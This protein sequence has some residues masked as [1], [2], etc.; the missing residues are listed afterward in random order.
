MSAGVLAT[1]AAGC[2]LA[3]PL[4][5][6]DVPTAAAYKEIAPWTLAQPADRLPR[7]AWWTLY[8]DAQLDDLQKQL[9]ASNPDLAAALASY[10]QARAFSDEAGSGLFPTLTGN[11]GIERNRQSNDA[12]LRG[13][14]VG[15]APTFYD[16]NTVGVAASYELDLWGQVRNEVASGNA[17]AAASAADLESVRLSLLAQLADDYIQL[18][19]FDR[20]SAI[21]DDTVKAYSRALDLTRQRHDGGI[22]PGLDV[23]QA[24]TQ[25]DVARSQAA[26]VLAQRALMEH[27]IAA[28]VGESASQFSIAPKTDAIDL[29]QVPTGVPSTLLQRRPDVAAA[30]RRMVAANA[31][32]GV[33]RAAFFPA[34]TL[35]ASGGY[36]SDKFA[37]LLQQ[38]STLWAIGPAALLTIFDAGKHRAQVAQARAAFDQASAKY[39]SVALA[40]FAQVEDNL[41]LLAHDHD[42][43]EAQKSAV[44]SAQRSLDFAM[45]RY[46]NGAVS[47]LDVVAS[48]TAALQT[49]RDALDL[50][51][52]QLRASVALI[53][54]L[55]GGWD[56]S[57]KMHRGLGS[58]SQTSSLPHSSP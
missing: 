54:A 19:G 31:D 24:Q 11:A 1:L 35:N 47:Y 28:L 34:I 30:Q 38:P 8:G 55:G 9:I 21:L 42:A 40:A 58:P 3:P 53:R 48:Q 13:P 41:A 56:D 22:A 33:A 26:Q 5:R 52:R 15:G 14:L 17:L 25:L 18:R 4:T 39:R 10:D 57:Q 51:T 12:A 20:D 23:S 43:S 7:D 45:D 46:R 44:A 32:I 29:P 27:A 49:R 36:E 50:E 6:P 37:N 16:T 2:S